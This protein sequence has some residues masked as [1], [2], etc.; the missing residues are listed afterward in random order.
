MQHIWPY[1]GWVISVRGHYA[2]HGGVG[3]VSA[4]AVWSCK[5]HVRRFKIKGMLDEVNMVAGYRN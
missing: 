4:D 2:G 5:I 3:R 1:W